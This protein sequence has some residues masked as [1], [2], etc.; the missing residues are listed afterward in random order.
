MSGAWEGG[1]AGGY[2][3]PGRVGPGARDAAGEAATD[4]TFN[5]LD[6][7]VTDTLMRDV[8]TVGTKLNQVVFGR[9]RN[10]QELRDWDLWGPLVFCILLALNL[11]WT[12]PDEQK[13]DVFALVFVVVWCGA[14]VVTLN[15]LLLGGNVSF[16]QSVCLL[17]YCIFP[18]NIA[19]LLTRVWANAWFRIAVTGVCFIWATRAS[20]PF[21]EGLVP[22]SRKILAVYPVFLFYLSMAWLVL[23]VA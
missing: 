15:T 11:T 20:V 12:A 3:A 2:V 21:I 17:G 9:G 18:L 13:A 8:R 16:F 1:G 14:G 7:S 19:A 5:T 6:E 10:G 22:E 23:I 4:P